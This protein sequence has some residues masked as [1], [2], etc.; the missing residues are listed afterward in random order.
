MIGAELNH[1]DSFI[2][3]EYII[4]HVQRKCTAQENT[5]EVLTYEKIRNILFISIIKP[6]LFFKYAYTHRH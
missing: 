1:Y 2:T 3:K 6:S 5:H 4:G